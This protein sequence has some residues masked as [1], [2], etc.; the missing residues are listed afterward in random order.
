MKLVPIKQAQTM[1][2]NTTARR[3]APTAL[4]LCT[5]KKDRWLQLEPT[6][7]GWNLVEHGYVNATTP[8]PSGRDAKRLLKEAFEREF[9]RSNKAYVEEH[10]G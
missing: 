5:F 7:Q 1:L 6:A 2:M 9:S 4:R 3:G 10:T 8:L